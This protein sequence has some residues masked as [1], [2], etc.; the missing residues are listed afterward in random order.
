[1]FLDIETAYLNAPL[2]QE[3]YVKQLEGFEVAG[4]ENQVYILSKVQ[5][6]LRQASRLWH[7]PFRAF[8]LAY[9]FSA[10]YANVSLYSKST[11]GSLTTIVVHVDDLVVTSSCKDSIVG[12]QR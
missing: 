11:G 4:K 12:A 10:I 2:N 8:L 3:I 9:G 7:R 5:Y 6:G 1:M